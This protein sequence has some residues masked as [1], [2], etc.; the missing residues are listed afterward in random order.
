M[1]KDNEQIERKDDGGD[2]LAALYGLTP[3]VETAIIDAVQ[4]GAVRRLRTLV[5]PL[6][7]ADQADLL[8]RMPARTATSLVRFLGDHLDAETLTYLDENTRESIVEVMGA[9]ALARQ[10][11]DLSTDDAI[12][13]IEELEEGA[14]ADVLAALSAEDRVF[15]EEGLSFPED[16]AGRLMQREIVTVPSFWTVG[17]TIDYLRGGKSTTDDFYLIFVVDPARKPLGEVPLSKL[18]CAQRPRRISEIME[19][20]FR[21]IPVD[22]DQEEVAVLFRRYGMVSAGVVDLGDRL[23]GMIT[24]DD[25]IDVIDEEAEE[26]LMA[27]A[28][29]G[30]ASLRSSI[31]ETLQGRTTWLLVNLLTAILASVVIGVFDATIE[32]LVALAVLMPIVASMGGNAGT[33]TV[34]VAVRAIALRQLDAVSTRNF[35]IREGLVALLNG[36][37]FACLAAAVS[38]IWFGDLKIATVMAVAMFANLLI[39]G[40]SG[41]LVP[42]G[43]LRA[44]VDPAVASSIFVTTITDVVGFFVFLGL[45]ALYLM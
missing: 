23:V 37:L 44:G 34:T 45:A 8:E 11:H 17:Q 28:G 9:K 15:V 36:L 43:L 24:I 29:V 38:F 16:S 39:A 31:R 1:I 27:L 12:D 20:K 22:M 26:D 41:T 2:R 5:A 7:P 6:H 35:V 25:V 14:L 30:E 32:Q 42:I 13:I 40:L 19:P 4:T 33:Q 21:S 10:L 18:L 3:K